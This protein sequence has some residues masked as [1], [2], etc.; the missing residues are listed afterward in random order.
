MTEPRDPD[1]VEE[2]EPTHIVTAPLAIIQTGPTTQQYCYQGAPVPAGTTEEQ[3]EHLISAGLICHVDDLDEL[4][5]P[6]VRRAV[7]EHGDLVP[8]ERSGGDVE[9]TAPL[10]RPLPG[11]SK[12]RWIDYAVDRGMDRSVAESLTKG[13][14]VDRYP[15]E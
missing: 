14:L 4:G 12:A 15:P 5:R 1:T 13:E 7:D 2:F 9:R 3:I 10:L 11:E 8:N 6:I